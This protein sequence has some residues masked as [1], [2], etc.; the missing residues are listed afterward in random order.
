MVRTQ[1]Y[2]KIDL[3]ATGR[4]DSKWARSDDLIKKQDEALWNSWISF[5]SGR[6]CRRACRQGSRD[7]NY[8]ATFKSR[9]D[10]YESHSDAHSDLALSFP[11]CSQNI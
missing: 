3:E 11:F 5:L 1:L 2:C 7:R 4:L 6:H 10:G 8:C 9:P